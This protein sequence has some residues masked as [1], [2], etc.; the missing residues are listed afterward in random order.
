M[1]WRKFSGL[2]PLLAA[3]A[4]AT[5]C[6]N[7]N[8]DPTNPVTAPSAP[9]GVTA[10]VNGTS[11]AIAWTPGSGATSQVVS[12]T[13][14]AGVE[15]DR[16][17]TFNNNTANSA[18]FDNSTAGNSY[19][20]QVTAVN[21][22]GNAGSNVAVFQITEEEPT[23]VVV[24][25]VISANT[26]WTADKTY[27]LDGPVFVGV[28]C[29]TDPASPLASCIAANLTIEPGTTIT[30]KKTPTDSNAR[31][32]FLVVNR[33]SKIIADATGS[34]T[35]PTEAQ[36][37]V[38]TSDQPR[39]AR[40]RGDWGG[41]V[42]NGQ[43][44][45]NTG[46]EASGE[47]GSGL[48]G[49]IDDTNS[50]GIMRGVR[51][52]FAGDDVT[53]TDQLNGIALQGTGAGTTIAWVQVAYNVDDGTEPFGGSASQTHMVVTGIG[54]DSFDGT[55]GYRGFIQ[56]AIAQQR[57]DEADNGFEFSN[58]GD[59]ET[60]T[61]YST[62][63][64]A[65]ATMV[66]AS[67]GE[68]DVGGTE[69]DIGALFREGS[70][71]RIFNSIVTNFND[72]GFCVEGTVAQSKADAAIGGNTTPGEYLALWSSILWANVN[73]T[74]DSDTNFN[75]TCNDAGFEYD[76]QT[77]FETAG[78][79]NMVADPMLAASHTSIGTLSS[80][81]D[82]TPAAMPVGYTPFDVST[83]NNE[84]GAGIVMPTDGRTLQATDYAGAIE[85]GAADL[86]YDGWTIWA[87]DGSD[88]RPNADGQ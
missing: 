20:A 4:L 66:G 79:N 81:P 77:Y 24:T 29:G 12:V 65:N 13:D 37:I 35:K 22:A 75:D 15:A 70:G 87:E 47:G 8:N 57:S 38:F 72:S 1:N 69:S 61:P 67:K 63:V 52:E 10:S 26:T 49:G 46:S 68:V 36:M 40:S 28:D 51:V 88:S 18:Q 31:A 19:A 54:D 73:R 55:D 3:I 74:D 84:G 39:G 30:G 14:V 76:T 32:S 11:V 9:T 80:P 53:A 78:F 16:T 45:I 5:G 25:G 64:V 34:D 2:L 56:F 60:L 23:S 44:P 62:A 50:S 71:W 86:W 82:F 6:S 43:A 42:L 85:P 83:F 17:Q 7:D 21:T 48:F 59:A 33:G 27:I 58:D 41:I